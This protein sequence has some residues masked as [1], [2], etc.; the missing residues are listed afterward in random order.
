MMNLQNRKNEER[1]TREDGVEWIHPILL[2]TSLE[3]CQEKEGEEEIGQ[4]S[5]L[6]HLVESALLGPI[7]LEE[8]VRKAEDLVR[9]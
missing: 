7:D 5:I 9:I 4:M 8:Q 3:F 6:I 2:M 1:S